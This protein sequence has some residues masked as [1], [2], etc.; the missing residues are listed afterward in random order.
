[1]PAPKASGSAGSSKAGAAT[2]PTI[3]ALSGAVAKKSE[4]ARPQILLSAVGSFTG[5]RNIGSKWSQEQ[6]SLPQLESRIKYLEDQL[7][8]TQR[9][10]EGLRRYV[11]SCPWS[12]NTRNSPP[13]EL[14]PGFGLH[15]PLPKL[16]SNQPEM[17]GPG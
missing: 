9:S 1:M 5:Y 17:N 2:A 13:A 14:F 12:G 16:N 10:L 11:L 8:A 3:S 15:S 7:S 6:T 4:S